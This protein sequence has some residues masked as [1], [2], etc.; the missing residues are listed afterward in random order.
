MDGRK[1]RGIMII[2]GKEYYFDDSSDY[3]DPVAMKGWVTVYGM[4]SYYGDDYVKVTDAVVDGIY[5]NKNGRIE[6]LAE[7]NGKLYFYDDG[8]RVSGWKEVDGKRYYFNPGNNEAVTGWQEIGGDKYYFDSNHVMLKDTVIDG[9]TLGP[10]GKAQEKEPELTDEYLKDFVQSRTDY[11]AEIF[12]L[13]NEERVKAG[14][15]PVE[16]DNRFSLRNTAVVGGSNVMEAIRVGVKTDDWN[17]ILD[18]LGDHGPIGISVAAGYE[19]S[20]EK[21]VANWMNSPL[22]KANVLDETDLSGAITYMTATYKGKTYTTI[23]YGSGPA[24]VADIAEFTDEELIADSVQAL[25]NHMTAE[26]HAKYLNWFYSPMN[27][28]SAATTSALESGEAEILTDD[29]LSGETGE[30]FVIENY[31]APGEDLLSD[32]E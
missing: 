9:I 7:R 14:R 12:R 5:L 13:V 2:G 22:H 17:A 20:P 1:C 26:E 21:V 11:A 10:D 4:E 15:K 6:G 32:G 18:V 29:S 31:T 19:I 23:M 27:V 8:S 28:A 30:E 25:R 24:S 16:W 3:S